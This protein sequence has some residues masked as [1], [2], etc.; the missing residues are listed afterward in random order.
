M[1]NP[2]TTFTSRPVTVEVAEWTG[3]YELSIRHWMAP[4]TIY[5]DDSGPNQ[6]PLRRMGWIGRVDGSRRTHVQ[7]VNRGDWL[8]KDGERIT[9]MTREALDREYVE[10]V[11]L[12]TLPPL[13]ASG[14]FRLP[15]MYGITLIDPSGV[16]G[17]HKMFCEHGESAENAEASALRRYR[18]P[19]TRVDPGHPTRLV[20][21]AQEVR[22]VTGGAAQT[23]RPDLLT[24][25]EGDR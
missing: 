16:Y 15:P 25:I 11:Q 4:Y 19:G 9:V 18:V 22:V 12:P 20:G 8:V 14:S 13:P 23:T 2:P 5:S 6:L 3:R 7:E 17:T 21:P 24:G 1:L 10:D